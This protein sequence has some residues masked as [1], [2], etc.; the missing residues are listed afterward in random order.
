M[1]SDEIV[2]NTYRN[3]IGNLIRAA[4]EYK[5]E[6]QIVSQKCRLRQGLVRHEARDLN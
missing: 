1:N 3:L 2:K 4:M 6:M 5:A